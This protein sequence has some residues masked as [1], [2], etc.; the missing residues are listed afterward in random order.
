[1]IATLVISLPTAGVGGQLVVRHK[2]NEIVMDMNA[3][4]SSEL[5]F[6]AFYADCKHETRPVSEGH[7]VSLVYNLI[8]RE[9]DPSSWTAPD[10]EKQVQEIAGLLMRLGDDGGAP[11]KIVWMFEHDY[12]GAGLSF[13]A[14]REWGES[15]QRQA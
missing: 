4:E 5:V 1:M 14:C 3:R 2:G 11:D 7:R 13:G 6:A 12:S 9:G 8:L 10:Y 15:L